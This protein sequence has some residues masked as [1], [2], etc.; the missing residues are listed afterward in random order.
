MNFSRHQG[1]GVKE[2]TLKY[3]FKVFVLFGI[4]FD[5]LVLY[6]IVLFLH[7]CLSTKLFCFEA[8]LSM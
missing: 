8:I 1:N 6:R 3:H 2:N 5:L 7:F 4:L